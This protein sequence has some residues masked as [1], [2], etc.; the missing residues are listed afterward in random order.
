MAVAWAMQ[1]RK[2][3]EAQRLWLGHAVAQMRRTRVCA[4]M[5]RERERESTRERWIRRPHARV[6]WNNCAD[7][8]QC[9]VFRLLLRKRVSLLTNHKNTQLYIDISKRLQKSVRIPA[10]SQ[11]DEVASPGYRTTTDPPPLGHEDVDAQKYKQATPELCA[12]SRAKPVG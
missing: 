11:S 10:P 12:H 1:S 2:C 6:I 7:I 3:A 8:Y 5:I 9:S 4:E